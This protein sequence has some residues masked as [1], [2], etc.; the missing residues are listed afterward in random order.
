[1]S[2]TN[3]RLVRNATK[4]S[5]VVSPDLVTPKAS[6]KLLKK[7]QLQVEENLANLSKKETSSSNKRKL[8]SPQRNVT[9][10][11]SVCI[12]IIT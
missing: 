11:E 5:T 4:K 6:L 8:L 12:M 10:D 7:S 9:S 3:K 2:E 1:M